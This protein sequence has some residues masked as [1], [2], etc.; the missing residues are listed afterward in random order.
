[1]LYSA[2]VTLRESADRGRRQFLGLAVR[3]IYLKHGPFAKGA[4]RCRVADAMTALLN[5][6]T[7]TLRLRRRAPG[8]EVFGGV[9]SETR[10]DPKA[11][12]G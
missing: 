8:M 1:M 10:A 9:N 6:A 5:A 2:H 4:V 12:V 7:V 3:H 11:A